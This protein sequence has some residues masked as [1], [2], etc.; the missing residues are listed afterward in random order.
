VSSV[1]IIA[2]AGVNHN[3][4]TELAFQ[5]VDA[6]L[7]AGVDAIKFQTFK[8]EKLVTKVAQKA[9]YQSQSTTDTESQYTMLK[10]LELG[11][12]SHRDLFDYCQSKGIDFLSTAFDAESLCFLVQKIGL[13]KLKVPS[14]D[15]TNGPLL[16]QHAMTGCDL[17]MSTGMATLSEIERALGVLAFGLLNEVKRGLKPSKEAFL[18]AYLSERGRKLLKEKVTLLHCTTEYPAPVSEINLHA[19][20]TMRSAFALDVGYSDHSEGIAVPTA[21]VAL[22]A[23][24]IEKH[25]T[26][27]RSL[28][29]PDHKASLEPTELK[30]MVDSIRMVEVAL[31]SGV[32][33]PVPSELKNRN[34]ARKSL[35]AGRDIQKG[36][37]FTEENL[38]AKRPGKGKS[39]MHYWDIL[40]QEADENFSQDQYL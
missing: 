11:H 26:L 22:G 2:E 37:V 20:G 34:V 8:A 12:K 28:P 30:S 18:D 32:K 33:G 14:G 19:M 5:L 13:K 25:F 24:L 15:I 29:G 36:E 27:D 1:Y 10:R 16:L 3:G 9:V 39:P 40:G 35:I 7:E 31:G 6:A 17:V 23:T 38:V 4:D 21:A